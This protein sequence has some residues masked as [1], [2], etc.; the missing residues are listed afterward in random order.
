MAQKL[1]S[2]STALALYNYE[3]DAAPSPFVLSF[4]QQLS[5]DRCGEGHEITFCDKVAKRFRD[6]EDE[7]FIPELMEVVQNGFPE[8]TNPDKAVEFQVGSVRC[9]H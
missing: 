7:F 9:P 5:G 4:A 6:V 2:L 3:A 8:G 1:V